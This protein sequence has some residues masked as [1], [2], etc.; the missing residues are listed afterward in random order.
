MNKNSTL[1][2][3]CISLK[4]LQQPP[5]LVVILNRSSES[6]QNS[7]SWQFLTHF[8]DLEH[9]L[10]SITGAADKYHSSI[11]PVHL[12]LIIAYFLEI[13]IVYLQIRKFII[14]TCDFAHFL[15]NYLPLKLNNFFQ[16]HRK[17][18]QRLQKFN[19]FA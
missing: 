1:S 12:Q 9:H 18:I 16:A 4:L 17:V 14:F 10:T 15:F 2:P 7:P 13:L 3:R 5:S 19:A 6:Y 11:A 8:L